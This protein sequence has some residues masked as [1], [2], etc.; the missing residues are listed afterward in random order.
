MNQFCTKTTDW[1]RKSFTSSLIYFVFSGGRGGGAGGPVRGRKVPK[2]C[3]FLSPYLNILKLKNDYLTIRFTSNNNTI[4]IHKPCHNN[5]NH[6]D[7]S[8]YNYNFN[9]LDH[10]INNRS[11]S[12][13]STSL[14]T[15]STTTAKT[16]TFTTLTT[17]S[18]TDAIATTPEPWPTHYQQLIQLQLWQIKQGNLN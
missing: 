18:T 12:Y 2:K 5:N 15:T 4:S 9:N 16:T 3:Y 8:C 7:N 11:Y 13:Y 1:R 17:T 14:I 6:I 10:H